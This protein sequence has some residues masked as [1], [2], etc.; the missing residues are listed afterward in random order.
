MLN[1]KEIV[2]GEFG[3]ED[4]LYLDAHSHL[5]WC[6]SNLE[7]PLVALRKTSAK[8]SQQLPSLFSF[9]QNEGKLKMFIN[10]VTPQEFHEVSDIT[11]NWAKVGLGLHPWYVEESD[12]CLFVELLPTTKFIGEIGLDFSKKFTDAQ[13][14]AQVDVFE[15]VCSA[16]SD[17]KIVSVH[18]FK[19]QGKTHEILKQEGVLDNSVVIYHWFGDGPS[20]LKQAI[21]DN[22]LFSVN[23]RM[24]STRKG[25][26]LAR[27]IPE[28]QLL[29]ETDMPSHKGDFWDLKSTQESIISAWQ[30]WTKMANVTL[31]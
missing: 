4:A 23:E 24:L 11:V 29:F 13:K 5:H 10:T 26:E 25:A 22:C 27:M 18:T 6:L 9:S 19:T 1:P 15:K 7:V 21:N 2:L 28:E 17:T 8:P 14:Q 12:L 30:K 16:M 31:K 3:A 20:E